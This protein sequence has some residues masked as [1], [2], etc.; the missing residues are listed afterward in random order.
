MAYTHN[1]VYKR[2]TLREN[3]R[4]FTVKLRNLNGL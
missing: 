2:E 3:A 4:N 1:I